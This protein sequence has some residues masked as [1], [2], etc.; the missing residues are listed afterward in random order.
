MKTNDSTSDRFRVI[1]GGGGVA[2]L[3]A[4][5]ALRDLAPD[6]VSLTM[7][8][9]NDELVYRPMTVREPFAYAAA[10]RYSLEEMARDLDVRLVR[11]SFAGA[12]QHARVARTESGEDIPYDALM[13]C[14][15][16][17][18]V[19]RYRHAITIDDRRLDELLHGLIRDIEGGYV[20]DLAFVVPPRMAWPFPL[21]ELA[22]MSARRAYDAGVELAITLLTP[23]DAPLAIFGKATS[24]G[25]LRLL[26]ENGIEVV[27]PADC[28]I[29]EHG[30]IVIKPDRRALASGRAT[31]RPGQRELRVD[32]IVALPELEGP[33]VPGLPATP[34]GFLPVD[35]HCQV[36]GVDR[37]YAAGDATDFPIKFGGIAAQQADAAAE[38]IAAL[39][40][41]AVTPSVFRPVVRGILLTGAEPRYLT[42][43]LTGGHA[44]SSKF[45]ETSTWSSPSKIAAKYLAPYLE[46]LD[47]VTETG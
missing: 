19:T 22:L 24:R 13:L 7:I 47:R 46:R 1:L 6:R 21:Y 37:I 3:E 25:A 12:D 5:L 30:R 29:P 33:A 9:P 20:H 35:L 32:R 18:L 11:D 8:A 16:A 42:A 45:T 36:R 26:T 28:E 17:R 43:H 40:G 44:F 27:A 23:E 34:R 38:A 31:T 10:E 41:A 15:G 14:L 4:A 2:A 39:A